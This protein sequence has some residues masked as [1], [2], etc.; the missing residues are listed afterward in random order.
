MSGASGDGPQLAVL[1]IDSDRL[2]TSGSPGAARLLGYPAGEM[3]GNP[4]TFMM[5]SRLVAEFEAVVSA[6][7]T[8]EHTEARP[9][10][11]IRQGGQPVDVDLT[12]TPIADARGQASGAC[13][14]AVPRSA[15]AAAPAPGPLGSAGLEATFESA[16]I[17]MALVSREGCILKVNRALSMLLGYTA[18]E[19]LASTLQTLTNAADLGVELGYVEQL[20]AGGIRSYRIEK[21]FTAAHRRHV[22]VSP[23][24][25]PH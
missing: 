10:Q 14:V 19:L 22:S 9:F 3:V 17:G 20:L 16:P 25:P 23:S 11:L 13:L 2:I 4:F 7:F 6:S 8:G 15:T 21:R 5:P 18:P 1:T 24:S 12:V